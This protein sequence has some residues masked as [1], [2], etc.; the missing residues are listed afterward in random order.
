MKS[1]GFTIVEL[2]II[3]VVI[4]ILMGI[5]GLGY[6]AWRENTIKNGLSADLSAAASAMEQELN[7]TNAYPTTT[8]KA[9]KGGNPVVVKS[10]SMTS[11]PPS[12]CLE[13]EKDS[14]K[15]HWKNGYSRAQDGGC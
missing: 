2:L 7:F 8:P 4:A 15:M 3:I 5:V 9:Y 1:V 11:L 6:G 13:A 12:F 14:I 10:S